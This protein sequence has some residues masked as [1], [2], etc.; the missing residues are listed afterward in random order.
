MRNAAFTKKGYKQ[1][2]SARLLPAAAFSRQTMDNVP[3]AVFA[4]VKRLA[5]GSSGDRWRLLLLLQG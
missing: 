3:S 4:Q 5:V 1:N 2:S